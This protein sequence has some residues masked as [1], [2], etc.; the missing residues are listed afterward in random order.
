MKGCTSDQLARG[1]ANANSP[2]P[3]R[4][5][6]PNG[7]DAAGPDAGSTVVQAPKP[8]LD[9]PDDARCGPGE[10]GLQPRLEAR[11]P[12]VE[13]KSHVVKGVDGPIVAQSCV[14]V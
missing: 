13:E 5:Q 14:P 1:I 7:L 8:G 4:G 12:V 10:L 9:L 6:L 11:T 3:D 2:L